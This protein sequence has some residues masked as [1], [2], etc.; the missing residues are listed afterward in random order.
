MPSR[1]PSSIKIA[2]GTARKHRQKNEPAPPQGDA[3]AP[4]WLSPDALVVWQEFSPICAAMGTL[5]T[6]DVNP[7]ARYCEMLIQWRRCQA[8]VNERGL[9]LD[10]LTE[11]GKAVRCVMQR[12]E[13]G[14]ANRLAIQLR[15][16][17]NDLG[18]NAV[19]RGKI[20]LP[21]GRKPATKDPKE[22]FFA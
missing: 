13:C 11:D 17:E 12:P 8:I 6:A 14:I 3:V 4:S 18:L 10:V 16:L 21:R 2:R 9:T 15:A 22:R 19:S 20:D 1:L 5:T 7:L